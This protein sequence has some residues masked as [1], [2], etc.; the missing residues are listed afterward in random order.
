MYTRC[1]Q[2][3]VFHISTNFCIHFVYKIKRAMVVKIFIQNVYKSFVEMWDTFCIH[4]VYLLYSYINS[5]LQ[6]V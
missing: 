6:K 3:N 4:L 2:Q 5:D 1:I